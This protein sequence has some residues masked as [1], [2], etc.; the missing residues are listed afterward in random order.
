ML[1]K[2]GCLARRARLWDAVPKDCEWLLVADPRHV[3]YLSNFMVH[4]LTFSAGE[5]CWL[6]L[7]RDGKNT[8]LGDNFSLK[9]R[10]GEPFVDE[11]VMV[12]WYDHKHSVMNRD[13]ALLNAAE[14]VAPRLFGRAG[15]VEAEWLPV[16]AFELMG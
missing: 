1:T 8:L 14:Q 16:G 10:T 15:A 5:R 13:H 4:P 2:E 7:E 6:L 3:L 11:E 9:S 12:K